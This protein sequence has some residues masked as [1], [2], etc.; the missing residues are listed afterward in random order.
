M[1]FTKGFSF[2]GMD[3]T[4]YLDARNILNLQNTTTVYAV[5]NDVVNA[6]HNRIDWSGDS[7]G[8]SNEASRSGALEADGSISLPSASAGCGN[9][10]T[11]D[12]TAAA[13]NCV[14]LIRAEERWGD[15]D[16]V[17]TLAEQRRASDAQFYQT[18]GLHNL[19]ANGRRLR[20]G[21]ELNF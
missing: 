8:F 4:A 9:W 10:L 12:G 11:Q 17:F 21:M 2:G 16:H 20:L 6:D 5:T 7:T 19:T 15:G 13:P 1:R 18:N 14:Y 3:L